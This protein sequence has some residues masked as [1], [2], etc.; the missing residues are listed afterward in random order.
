MFKTCLKIAQ[1]ILV[2]TIKTL[3]FVCFWAVWAVRNASMGVEWGLRQLCV[4]AQIFDIADPEENLNEYEPKFSEDDLN[5]MTQK[6]RTENLTII[7]IQERF[8]ISYRQA[9]KIKDRLNI[10]QNSPAIHQM[11]TV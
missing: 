2:L 8:N 1:K 9:K 11:A 4:R 6:I 10:L 5:V 7:Q 3:L